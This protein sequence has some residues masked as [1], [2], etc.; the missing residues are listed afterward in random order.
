MELI[1][2][3]DLIKN[4][5]T[6]KWYPPRKE[7]NTDSSEYDTIIKTYSEDPDVI[8][9]VVKRMQILNGKDVKHNAN[10]KCRIWRSGIRQQFN[11]DNRIC[12]M[13]GENDA[14][15]TGQIYLYSNIPTKCV[16]RGSMWIDLEYYENI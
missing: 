12:L 5:E 10:P 3:S 13:Y 7:K 6:V 14:F 8:R 2:K 15:G 11:C 4:I 9:A 1:T 16:L